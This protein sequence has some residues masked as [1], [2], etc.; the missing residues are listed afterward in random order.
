MTF[1]PQL[2]ALGS[3]SLLEVY[4]TYDIPRLFLCVSKSRAREGSLWLRFLQKC[5]RIVGHCVTFSR[6]APH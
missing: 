6:S 3:L 2:G 5:A 4:E 1:L